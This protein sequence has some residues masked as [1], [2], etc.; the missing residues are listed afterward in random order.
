MPQFSGLSLAKLYSMA[1]SPLIALIG[2][3]NSG[4]SSLFNIITNSRQRVGNFPGVTVE[5]TEG[6][7][8]L[9]NQQT[10]RILDLPGAYSIYPK[11]EDEWVV[12]DCLFNPA[13]PLDALILVL[14]ATNLKRNLLFATQLRELNIPTI[15]VLTMMDIAK[16]K[17]IR[18][19]IPELER[20][21]GVPIVVANPRRAKGGENLKKVLAKVLSNKELLARQNS[22]FI[23][24]SAYAT[25]H[26]QQIQKLYDKPI[27]PYMALHKAIFPTRN[28]SPKIATRI[29]ELNTKFNFNKT[30]AQA[31]EI[32]LRYGKIDRVLNGVLSE[33]DSLAKKL[34]TDK[35]D[36]I[37]LHRYYGYAILFATFFLTFQLIFWLAQYPME[38]LENTL[39]WIEDG[40]ANILPAYIFTP[41][42]SNTFVAKLLFS[43]IS[44]TLVFVPQIMLLSAIL[45]FLED[46]GYMARISFLSDNLMRRFGMNGK[47]LMPLVSGM[48]CAIPAVL[49]ARNIESRKERLLTIFTVPFITC[50]ARLP[51]FVMLTTLIIPPVYFFGFISLQGLVIMGLY[52]LGFAITLIVAKILSLLVKT[53]EKSIFILELPLYKI[54]RAKTILRD[55]LFKTKL[56]ILD[57]GKIIVLAS[58]VL[59]CL[60]ALAPAQERAK[61][62]QEYAEKMHIDPEHSTQHELSKNSALMNHSYAAKIGQYLQPVLQPLGYN[63]QIG[64]AVLASFAAREVFIGTLSTLYAFE[65]DEFENNNFVRYNLPKIKDA[66]GKQVFSLA[67]A[68]S[69]LIFY[70]FAMQCMSTFAM[71]KRETRSWSFAIGQFAFMGTLAYVCATITYQI[72]HTLS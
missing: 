6:I 53:R 16:N 49:A 59:T 4:K 18:V 37:L 72:L 39:S 3:P 40:F 44:T 52:I 21:L 47:S 31:E 48:A 64:V 67:T 38:L 11:K 30:R 28:N 66:Q 33:A 29:Q 35:L 41:S 27:S 45:T 19:D 43:G 7:C 25:E 50:S 24:H 55:V 65:E 57:V 36:N 46:T 12:Y 54:P 32:T 17:Q 42:I 56:F 20:R 70:V 69:L 2:N 34:F 23:E 71:V 62:M 60:F 9:E 63:W 51:I 14:D 15:I 22:A 26:I 61:I 68:F 10:L 1:S 58:V 5:R 13:E 8:T